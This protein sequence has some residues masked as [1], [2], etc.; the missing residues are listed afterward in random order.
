SGSVELLRRVNE[1][2]A[3]PPND[4]G[5]ACTAM[6][7]VPARDQGIETVRDRWRNAGPPEKQPRARGRLHA[8]HRIGLDPALPLQHGPPQHLKCEFWRLV[9]GHRN[10]YGRSVGIRSGQGT[11]LSVDA[12]V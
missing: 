7:F 10:M 8:T 1:P 9:F 6:A 5:T 3:H 2:I 4:L 11:R 12:V